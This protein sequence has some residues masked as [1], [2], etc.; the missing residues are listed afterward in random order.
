MSR[1]VFTCSLVTLLAACG[2]QNIAS[3]ERADQDA[4]TR[5]NVACAYVGIAPGNAS[6]N[7]C[8]NDLQNSLWAAQSL[9]DN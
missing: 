3:I 7:Q 5:A 2:T 1:I 8:A 6:F 9:S 4:W